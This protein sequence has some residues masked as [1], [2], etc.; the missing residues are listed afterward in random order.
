[1]SNNPFSLG[2]Y[3]VTPP[4]LSDGQTHQVELDVNANLKI[5]ALPAGAAIIGQVE[6]TDGTNVLGTSSHPVRVDP[7]GGTTQPVSGTVTA[8][9]GTGTNLHV[10]V[11]SAPTTAVTGTVTANAGTGTFATQDAAD[12]STGSAVPTKATLVGA[13]KSGNLTALLLDASGNLN[14]NVAAGGG[15]GGTSSTFG[16]AFPSTGTAVG[17]TDGTN[18]QPLAVDASKN[19]KII[20]NAALPAGTNV[21]GHVIA[22]SGSTTAVTSLPATPAGTN[23]IGKVGIDQTTPGTTNAV[24]DASDGSVTAGTA[25]TKSSLGGG[26]VATSAPSPTIGQQIA[27]QLDSNGNQRVSPFGQTGSF[28]SKTA[29]GTGAAPPSLTVPAATKWVVKTVVVEATVANSGSPRQI[30]CDVKDASSN[31]IGTFIAGVLAPINTLTRFTAGPSIPTATSIVSF[32]ATIAAPEFCLGPSFTINPALA[33]GVSGDTVK[34]IANVI[35]I[36]D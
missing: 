35:V 6:V 8:T 33:V 21:I 34:V 4:T 27:I 5:A 19:L 30:T 18:M 13:S 16:S 11:D 9:Q 15:S 7:T 28:T 10:V 24:Q 29:S 22:D 36:P 1:M 20:V 23:L 2:T 32:N 12:G 31:V 25:A 3:N 14:V 26:V 17:A